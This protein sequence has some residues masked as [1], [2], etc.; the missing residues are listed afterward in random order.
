M[1]KIR[2]QQAETVKLVTQLN[3]RFEKLEVRLAALEGKPNAPA[4]TQ[5]V[6]W[7]SSA[8]PFDLLC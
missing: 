6:S 7:F 4:Q 2:A 5:A 3:A 1:E 8:F